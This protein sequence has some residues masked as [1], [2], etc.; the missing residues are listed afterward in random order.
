MT[1]LTLLLTS[2]SFDKMS[3]PKPSAS[4]RF[5]PAT[6]ATAVSDKAAKA[7]DRRTIKSADFI[8][9]ISLRN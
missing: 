6:Q 4:P 8:G 2:F 1:A 5:V 7:D 9:R 3:R